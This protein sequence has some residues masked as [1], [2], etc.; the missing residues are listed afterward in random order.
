MKGHDLVSGGSLLVR[1][2]MDLASFTKVHVDLKLPLL[3]L[4][5]RRGI[6]ACGY[7]NPATFEKTGEV[8][9]IVSGVRTFEDMLEAKLQ[10][11][12]TEAAKLGL[13]VG[14]RGRDALM[15]LE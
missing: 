9:A 5:G 8:A 15:L 7:L 6:L 1:T 13:R 11:V 14:M 10:S 2:V 4:I 12:S 3:M